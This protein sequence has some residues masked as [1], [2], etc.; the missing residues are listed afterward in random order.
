[1][2][3]KP[4]RI[5]KRGELKLMSL[6]G[7]GL[8]ILLFSIAMIQFTF[9]FSSDNNSNHSIATDEQLNN[10]LINFQDRIN[11]ASSN[12]SSS[13]DGFF[14]DIPL[15]GA[16][17]GTVTAIFGVVPAF[18]TQTTAS[19]DLVMGFIATELNVPPVVLSMLTAFLILAS[20]LLAWR[21]YKAGS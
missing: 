7:F 8:L 16:I 4:K 13:K 1:M 9:T 2:E 11:T 17:E 19:Y 21:V 14:S 5:N 3:D 20:L 6:V 18:I 15:L 10:T 12:F